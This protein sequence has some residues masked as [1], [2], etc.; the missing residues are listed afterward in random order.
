M[1]KDPWWQNVQGPFP[2]W[3][4]PKGVKVDG[5][6]ST[7]GQGRVGRML[8]HRAVFNRAKD[9]AGRE[10]AVGRAVG[11][12]AIILRAVPLCFCMDTPRQNSH[13]RC[14]VQA[15]PFP[16][17]AS[18]SHLS[19]SPP[20]LPR[21]KPRPLRAAN[22]APCV[23]QNHAPCVPS[24][25][26]GSSRLSSRAPF[27]RDRAPRGRGRGRQRGRGRWQHA[28]A[29]RCV[30]RLAGGCRA[31]ARPRGQGGVKVGQAVLQRL[32]PVGAC[33]QGVGQPVHLL[34]GPGLIRASPST[35]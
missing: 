31:A 23:P 21:R 24:L 18:T 16:R 8:L 33:Q 17:P 26:T 12:S 20:R 29:Q 28:T 34:R 13:K 6:G 9:G 3:K 1:E 30:R 7:R 5:G 2:T 4:G 25:V 14:A 19:L 15:G 10:A 27:F 35:A 22:H 11:A 32:C